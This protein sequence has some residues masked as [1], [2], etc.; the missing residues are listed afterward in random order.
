MNIF[1]ET[2]DHIIE[3]GKTTM[4][5]SASCVTKPELLLSAP[6]LL[7]TVTSKETVSTVSICEK[8]TS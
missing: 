3:H 8:G 6:Q 2:L 1:D 7:Y 5:I 4:A